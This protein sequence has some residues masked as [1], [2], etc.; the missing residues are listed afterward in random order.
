MIGMNDA[1]LAARMAVDLPVIWVPNLPQVR[2][3]VGK[4]QD[5][6]TISWPMCAGSYVLQSSAT[7]G[8]GAIWQEVPNMPAIS[9][10][11]YIAVVK[12]DLRQVFTG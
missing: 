4:N 5:E 6:V 11:R 2:L 3:V 9:G 7:L 12:L 10:D 1:S 8:V